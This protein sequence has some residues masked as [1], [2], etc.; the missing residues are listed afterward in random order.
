MLGIDTA[1]SMLTS[2][3][4]S[5]CRNPTGLIDQHFRT[6]DVGKLTFGP[7]ACAESDRAL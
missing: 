7:S 1:I 5:G 2:I 4:Q 3:L 6:R